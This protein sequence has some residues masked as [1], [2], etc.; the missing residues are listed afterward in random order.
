MSRAG[1]NSRASAFY[2]LAESDLRQGDTVG[3]RRALEQST[4]ADDRLAPAHVLLAML[5]EQAREY[6][7]AIE[8]YRRVLALMPNDPVAL[9]N[10]AYALA[11]RRNEPR[12]ALPLAEKAYSLAKGNPNIADTLGWIH[13]LLGNKERSLQLMKE[14]S[15]SAPD[16]ADIHLHAAV[17]YAA[18]ARL[19]LAAR[20]LAKATEINPDID[21]YEEAQ[22]LHKQLQKPER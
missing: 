20:E 11:V 13:H 18:D 22:Q 15:Q 4:A 12:Q 5:Y 19:D 9:N 10:L 1:V 3:A 7:M 6:D 14:A 8:R 21:K 16:N 2:L 17:V